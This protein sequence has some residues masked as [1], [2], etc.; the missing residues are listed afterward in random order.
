MGLSTVG[1]VADAASAVRTRLRRAGVVGRGIPL[2]AEHFEP[3]KGGW[4]SSLAVDQVR[5]GADVDEYRHRAMDGQAD[6]MES[7]V[8]SL[9]CEGE[10]C[11]ADAA[12]RGVEDR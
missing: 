10:D 1:A 5:R 4:I 8:S 11:T 3:L 2:V 7:D 9:L 12:H 6:S